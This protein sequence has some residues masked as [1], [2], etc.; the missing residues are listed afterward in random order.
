MSHSTS[1]FK[2]FSS[3]TGSTDK[4]HG[5][6]F[7]G[8]NKGDAGRPGEERWVVYRKSQVFFSQTKM[9]IDTRNE[10]NN[11][12]KLKTKA[13]KDRRLKEKQAANTKKIMDERKSK[14]MKENKVT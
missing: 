8:S 13:E 14:G 11:D 6:K 3:K 7:C 12:P 2:Y 9:A 5:S 10:V 1:G 4:G